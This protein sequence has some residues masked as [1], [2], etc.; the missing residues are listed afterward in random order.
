MKYLILSQVE[1]QRTIQRD[2]YIAALY[3]MLKKCLLSSYVMLSAKSFKS[4]EW[5]SIEQACHIFFTDLMYSA[6]KH[7]KTLG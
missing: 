6:C 7:L 5:S 4:E 1:V 2:Y 3:G